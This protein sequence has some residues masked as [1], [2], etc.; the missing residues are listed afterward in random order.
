MTNWGTWRQYPSPEPG[1]EFGPRCPRCGER[2]NPDAPWC[3]DQVLE[4]KARSR[5]SVGYL[6]SSGY[7]KVLPKSKGKL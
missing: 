2:M 6:G 3:F 4:D 5:S 7:L 1:P